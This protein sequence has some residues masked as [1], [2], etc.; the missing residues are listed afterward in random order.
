MELSRIVI[1]KEITL[2]KLPSNNKIMKKL[3]KNNKQIV[4]LIKLKNTLTSN[5]LQNIQIQHIKISIN[6]DSKQI[7]KKENNINKQL[8]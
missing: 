4:R 2:Q 7:D 5:V 8:T 3:S 6:K 1:N